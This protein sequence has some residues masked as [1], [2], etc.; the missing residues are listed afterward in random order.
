M[1]MAWR[2]PQGISSEVATGPSEYSDET[3]SDQ[4]PSEETV[5]ASAPVHAPHTP[6]P[7]DQ[8]S[9]HQPVQG[10]N[11]PTVPL[12]PSAGNSLHWLLL[13]SA[14]ILALLLAATLGAPVPLSD[15]WSHDA[16]RAEVAQ[17]I[18]WRFGGE[19][20]LRPVRL[21]AG[22]LVG[23]SLATS[24]AALQ[25]VFRNPLAEPY[26][27]GISAGGALGAAVGVT[28]QG[29]AWLRVLDNNL[30]DASS[31]LAFG[32]AIGASALVY[33]LGRGSRGASLGISDR[34]GLLLTGVAVSSFLAALMALVVALS[35]R[36]DLAQQ[37][38]FWMLGGL[39]RATSTQN[40]VLCVS[41]VVGLGTLL[42]SARDLNALRAGDEEAM[43]LGVPVVALHRRLLLAAALMSA[44]A[45]AT[46][47]LIG[48]V[49][50]LAPHLIRLVFGSNARAMIPA[51]A[52]GGATLLVSCDAVAR[53]VVQPVEL[54]VGIITAL[55][56]VPLFLFL[57]RRS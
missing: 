30:F 5:K 44:A 7:H 32:G 51:A 47:G 12:R 15:L 25:A 52:V 31:V 20:G 53:S 55:L 49:G 28:L 26:L 3:V 38:M 2:P 18:F 43:S 37:I 41:F 14:F 50:L 39:T 1:I 33:V 29:V 42:W 11:V 45:V 21:L 22:V 48:F 19:W 35:N 16:A 6:E 8:T 23:A 56:G 9:L 4:L 46:A 27:L 17:R 34:G 54:P 57:A 24:G 40:A 36:A 13:L 10:S